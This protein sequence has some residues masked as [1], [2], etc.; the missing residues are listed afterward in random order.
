M[1]IGTRIQY[2]EVPLAAGNVLSDGMFRVRC[3]LSLNA[4]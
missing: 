3:P 2:T 4:D 1:G